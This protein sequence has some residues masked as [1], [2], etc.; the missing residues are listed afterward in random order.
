MELYFVR[1]G[2]TA[3]N[4][5][6]RAMGQR[7]DGE[8]DE[9]GLRQAHEVIGKL[10]KDFTLIYSS[11]LKR[12]AT[13]AKIIA[14]YF[15]KNIII[16]QKLRERD[17]GTLSGKTWHEMEEETGKPMTQL[18]DDLQYDYTPYGGESVAQ[19]KARLEAFLSEVK[20]KH[21]QDKVIVVTH[22]GLISLM[23]SIYPHKKHAHESHTLP[24]TSIHKFEI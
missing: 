8:L 22:F 19:V 5:Q 21:P 18:D 13:T 10:P 23:N 16:D 1:H 4:K 12:A 6:H 17:F 24:N 7:I 2:E 9:T 11:P 15:D 20:A 14:D 3:F